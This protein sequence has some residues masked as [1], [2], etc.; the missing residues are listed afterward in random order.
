MAGKIAEEIHEKIG[1]KKG[2]YD[3][4]YLTKFDDN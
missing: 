1:N 3:L 2:C 4:F